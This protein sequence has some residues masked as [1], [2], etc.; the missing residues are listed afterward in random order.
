[1]SGEARLPGRL[2][3]RIR[4][5]N[6]GMALICAG[7]T[8]VLFI[9]ACS[10]YFYG[11]AQD[12]SRFISAKL[13]S[14]D[15]VLFSYAHTSY[16]MARGIA[17]FPDGGKARYDADTNILGSYD[18]ETGAI[19]I[20]RREHNLEW[21]PDAGHYHI[22][23]AMGSFAVLNQ[24]GQRAGSYDQDNRYW[25]INIENGIIQELELE[26]ELRTRGRA[27]GYIYM[28]RGDGT[29][30]LICPSIQEKERNVHWHRDTGV[31]PE[32]W[33][34]YPD[35]GY[36]RIAANRHYE[37]V[38]DG[39]IIYWIPGSRRFMS[40]DLSSRKSSERA[41]YKYPPYQEVIVDVVP[42]EEG[43][44]L[45]LGHKL[46]GRWIYEPLDLDPVL[47]EN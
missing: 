47:L 35:G 8:V 42:A 43:R 32:L 11:E 38:S 12:K 40:Y 17:A 4:S 29:L 18:P 21:Q 13:M 7:A 45:D 27:L 33:V 34:R 6:K 23:Q 20:F 25:L 30:L 36:H 37:G 26:R 9:N 10:D 44:R 31:I 22:L 41:D 46:D 28:V 5:W 14:G 16:R 1:M 3:G 39:A 2:P 24:G 19:R 15:R